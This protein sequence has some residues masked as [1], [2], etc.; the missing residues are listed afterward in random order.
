MALKKSFITTDSFEESD[1]HAKN[2]GYGRVKPEELRGPEKVS[3]PMW[4]GYRVR[5]VVVEE[6][7]AERK[8]V[9]QD[10]DEYGGVYI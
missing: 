8:A 10:A 7:V 4:K 3:A 9:H 5:R 1:R 6:V 2:S